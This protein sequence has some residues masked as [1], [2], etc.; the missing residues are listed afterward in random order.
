MN[1]ADN[2]PYERTLSCMCPCQSQSNYNR[3]ESEDR[4]KR[5]RG[6]TSRLISNNVMRRSPPF[7]LTLIHQKAEVS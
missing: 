7:A 5:R 1:V 3:V 6:A 2:H 4:E